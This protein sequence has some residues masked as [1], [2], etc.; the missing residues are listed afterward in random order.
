MV[1]AV[2]GRTGALSVVPSVHLQAWLPGLAVPCGWRVSRLDAV[3]ATRVLTRQLAPF[4]PW[5]ACEVLNLYRVPGTV[6]DAV[7]L[8]NADRTLRE[9]NGHD[10]QTAR[11]DIPLRYG[12]V[13]TCASGTLRIGAHAVRSQY[14]YYA[15]NAAGGAALIEQIVLV[16]S[17]VYSQLASELEE[18]T[19]ALH[20]SLLA[21]ID[22][23]N[24][25]QASRI[26]SH[27]RERRAGVVE[28]SMSATA[29]QLE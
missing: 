11:V 4:R 9:C 18:L 10:I 5:D 15:V 7:L 24:E 8:A 17:D 13:A 19:A 6:P 26:G 29:S 16:G 12:A 28:T 3:D 21:S 14:N 2:A 23:A 27:A 25:P 1:E 20:H 22:S